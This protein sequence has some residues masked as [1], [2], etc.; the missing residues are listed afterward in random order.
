MTTPLLDQRVAVVTG[1]DVN[2]GA[3]IDVGG[4]RLM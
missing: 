2:E 1:A 3:V 4:G